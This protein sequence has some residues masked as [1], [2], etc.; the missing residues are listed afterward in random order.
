M[1]ELT[2]ITTAE[3]ADGYRLAGA[4]T[5]VSASPGEAEELLHELLDRGED[6]VIAVHEPFLER[7]EDGFRRQL[8][9]RE[10]P[11]V[12]GLPS[13]EAEEAPE[14]R[15]ARLLRR[16]RRAVGYEITFPSEDGSA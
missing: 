7:L 14:E 13:G 8:E 9:K 16:L 12:V 4:A 5:R 3:L 1:S 6:G 11:L 2:V 10:A 15:R